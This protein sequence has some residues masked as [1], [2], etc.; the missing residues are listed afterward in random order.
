MNSD[1]RIYKKNQSMHGRYRFSS[2]D[3][4]FDL[5]FNIMAKA[6]VHIMYTY[7]YEFINCNFRKVNW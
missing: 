1:M 5:I 6:A 2:N 7:I 3:I 4:V